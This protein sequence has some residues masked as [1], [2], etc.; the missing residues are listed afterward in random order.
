MQRVEQRCGRAG[1]R[2]RFL[3]RCACCI[4]SAGFRVRM[5]HSACCLLDSACFLLRAGCCMLHVT[6]CIVHVACCA[7][8]RRCI[9]AAAEPADQCR[10]CTC[11]AGTSRWYARPT[12]Q[13]NQQT[14]TQT[15][16][17]TNKQTHA[18]TDGPAAAAAYRRATLGR[19]Q[20]LRAT[21]PSAGGRAGTTID[22]SQGGTRAGLGRSDAQKPSSAREFVSSLRGGRVWCST[23]RAGGRLYR[24]DRARRAGGRTCGV[25]WTVTASSGKMS[26][27]SSIVTL[28]IGAHA[29]ERGRVR[30]GRGPVQ[31]S[32]P[33]QVPGRC[34]Q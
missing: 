27:E 26:R 23:T 21:R 5:L 25:M 24:L 29:A 8:A 33:A 30:T 11:P 22:A 6:W 13:T 31:S 7:V 4:R 14:H 10:S 32:R 16:K 34:G 15:N 12:A 19:A 18:E 2:T 20:P 9:G 28:P 17:Q 3:A 1:G